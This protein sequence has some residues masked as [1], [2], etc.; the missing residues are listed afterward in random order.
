M[1]AAETS[2]GAYLP[3]TLPLA[4]SLLDLHVHAMDVSDTRCVQTCSFILIQQLYLTYLSRPWENRV[5]CDG[6]G[7]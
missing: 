2:Q 1:Q 3:L 5:G 7:T 4:A 6:Q